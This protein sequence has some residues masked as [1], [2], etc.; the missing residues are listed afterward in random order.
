MD[1][2]E[3]VNSLPDRP[4]TIN[5]ISNYFLAVLILSATLYLKLVSQIFAYIQG[6]QYRKLLVTQK[7]KNK[8]KRGMT[9]SYIISFYL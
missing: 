5:H 6:T 8:V 9:Y 4:S 1:F 3:K 7:T 2:Y